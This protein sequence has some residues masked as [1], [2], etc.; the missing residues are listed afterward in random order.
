MM[1]RLH[2]IALVNPSIR[3][4]RTR[5]NHTPFD[6][7]IATDHFHSAF[8]HTPDITPGL[9]T[10]PT[11]VVVLLVRRT[12]DAALVSGF[13]WGLS[14]SSRHLGV[15]DRRRADAARRLGS[16]LVPSGTP[17]TVWRCHALVRPVSI[18]SDGSAWARCALLGLVE[19]TR[20]P[21]TG[22][23]HMQPINHN[24]HTTVT[25]QCW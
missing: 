18:R 10:T 16:G 2:R 9:V 22:Q 23:S 21:A 12:L 20:E 1:K 7:C 19:H 3:L 17:F 4:V 11:V 13:V 6:H 24:I 5:I 25:C 15:C 14:Y 8:Y